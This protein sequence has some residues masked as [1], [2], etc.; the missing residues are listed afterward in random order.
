MPEPGIEPAGFTD[1]FYLDPIAPKNCAQGEKI[2]WILGLIFLFQA[3]I[4]GTVLF[5]FIG[6]RNMQKAIGPV[7]EGAT[8]WIQVFELHPEPGRLQPTLDF[9]TEHHRKYGCN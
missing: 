7:V 1:Q 2:E 4:L 9:S 6:L 5:G 3:I 8:K